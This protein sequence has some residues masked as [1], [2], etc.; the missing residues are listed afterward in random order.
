MKFYRFISYI[1]HP[2]IIPIASALLYFI[3]VP[4]A[5]SKAFSSRVLGIVFVMTYILPI[6]LLYILKR[7]KLIEDFELKTIN[8]RKFPVL[9]VAIIT[10]LLGRLLLQTG[11]A[12]LLAYSFY[13]CALA[14]GII[15]FLFFLKIKTSLHTVGLAGLIGFLTTISISFQLNVLLILM[16]LFVVLGLVA[17]AR[18][19]LKAHQPKEI[20]LGFIIGVCSQLLIFYLHR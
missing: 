4:V 8:E 19:F 3:L 1:F 2:V 16:I 18:L 14:L 9:F 10:F 17:T 15:Y 13:G 11:L 5:V 12:N 6:V 7:V 20:L